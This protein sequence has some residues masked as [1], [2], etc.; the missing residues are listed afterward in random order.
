MIFRF[1]ENCRCNQP[2]K[3]SLI[4]LSEVFFK[5]SKNFVF[6]NFVN[7]DRKKLFKIDKIY[8]IVKH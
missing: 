5:K 3:A 8:K 2:P 6:N 1:L 7:M 4:W